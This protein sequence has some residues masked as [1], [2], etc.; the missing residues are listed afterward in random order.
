[1]NVTVEVYPCDKFVTNLGPY[2]FDSIE[3]LR[4]LG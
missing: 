4:N 2:T 1:M 3:P